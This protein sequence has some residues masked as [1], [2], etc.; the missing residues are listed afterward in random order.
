MKN[1]TIKHDGK[2]YEL[3]IVTFGFFKGMELKTNA[4]K[5]LL[6]VISSFQNGNDLYSTLDKIGFDEIEKFI[7]SI[8]SK[9]TINGDELTKDNIDKIF[10]GNYSLLYKVISEVIETNGFLGRGGFNSLKQKLE[11]IVEV[12]E[13]K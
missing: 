10:V 12:Q 2:V 9:T 5:K 8:L 3:L 6:P 11:T 13:L 1:K 7:V 4:V